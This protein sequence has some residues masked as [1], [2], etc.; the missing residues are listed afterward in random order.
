MTVSVSF[1]D[2]SV[3][4]NFE[5]MACDENIPVLL[6]LVNSE[7]K[8]YY[9]YFSD[10]NDDELILLLTPCMLSKKTIENKFLRNHEQVVEFLENAPVSAHALNSDAEII[11]MNKLQHSMFGYNDGELHN[12]K[13]EDVSFILVN[14]IYY[15]IIHVF[16]LI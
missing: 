5:I 10:L 13:F 11:W 8:Y 2:P 3:N 7:S 15:H 6:K 16:F 1:I 9:G 14:H 12:K 4:D